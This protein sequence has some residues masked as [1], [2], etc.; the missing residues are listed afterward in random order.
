MRLPWP[1]ANK[2]TETL[3]EE[4]VIVEKGAECDLKSAF[5]LSNL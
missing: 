2:I 5:C 3:A 1:P 4:D